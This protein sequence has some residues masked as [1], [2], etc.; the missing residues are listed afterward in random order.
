[1]P[2]HREFRFLLLFFCPWQFERSR[3]P[4]VRRQA[5]PDARIPI[6]PAKGSISISRGNRRAPR[7][8]GLGG[9]RGNGPGGPRSLVQIYHLYAERKNGGPRFHFRLSDRAAGAYTLRGVEKPQG[10]TKPLPGNNSKNHR[11]EERALRYNRYGAAS[12][13]GISARRRLLLRPRPNKNGQRREWLPV[14]S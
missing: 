4:P 12:G 10:I 14:N 7:P 2:S 9:R 3:S 1:M 8:W 6:Y 5:I 13:F 11:A